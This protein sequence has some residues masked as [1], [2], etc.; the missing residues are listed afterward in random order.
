MFNNFRGGFVVC[1]EH[2]RSHV[3]SSSEQTE[4]L[5]HVV[6]DAVVTIALIWGGVVFE[7][8]NVLAS[9][10]LGFVDVNE[11]HESSQS[12]LFINNVPHGTFEIPKASQQNLADE[13]SSQEN[14]E[15]SN[16]AQSASVSESNTATG[17]TTPLVIALAE[18]PEAPT[19]ETPQE[20]HT[21]VSAGEG[22][23]FHKIWDGFSGEYGTYRKQGIPVF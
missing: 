4:K 2:K 13:N 19:P 12:S 21:T 16:F 17:Q 6:E 15:I 3:K 18:T 5:P 22:C 1:H 11:P 20:S 8:T 7:S 10:V 14:Q 9:E 23:K